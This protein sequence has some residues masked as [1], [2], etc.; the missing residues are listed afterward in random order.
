MII[1][2]KNLT[3]NTIV[4]IYEFEQNQKQR[5]II[6]MLIE[7]D[8]GKSSKSDKIE[9]T[10]NYHIICDKISEY[11]ENNSFRLLERL[12]YEVSQIVLKNP[13]VKSV[14]VEIDKPDAPIDN[15]ESVSVREKYYSNK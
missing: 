13:Q 2:I 7:Y 5:V 3:L 1:S 4:G 10:L 11:V 15:I 14:D 12:V 9:D 6:N 8:N